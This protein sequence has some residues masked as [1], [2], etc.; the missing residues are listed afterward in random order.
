MASFQKVLVANRG[1]VASRVFRALHG[2][3]IRS[4]AVY[5]DVDRELP[6][7]AE[8]GQ[9]VHL[10][11]SAP[12]ESYLS[13]D[14]VLAAA[15]ECGADA[16]HPGYGFLAENAEFA[17]RVIDAGLR[18]IGPS[19]RWLHDMGHKTQARRLAQQWGLPTGAGT[20]VVD[21]ADPALPGRAAAI[22]YP[23]MVKPAAGG[24]G[25]GMMRVETPE[26]LADA[27]RSARSAAERGFGVGDVYLEKL[28]R[29]PRHVEIQL[30]GD[31]H[32]HVAH[33]FD[34]DC[35]VQRRNQKVIEEAPAPGIATQKRLEVLRRSAAA[36]AA[37]GYDNI[38]TLE[39][40]MSSTG[41][42]S[43][44]EMN[45]RL[46]VEHGVSEEVTGVDLVRG[47]IRSAAGDSLA[48]ILP[49]EIAVRGHAIEARVC[50]EDPM[51]FFPSVGKL[52]V[53]RPPR[54]AGVRVET[55]YGEGSTVTPFYDSLLAKV[56]VHGKDRDAAIAGLQ[57][58]LGAFE[59]RGVK[60]N[61]PA[62]QMVLASQEFRSGHVHTG[63]LQE[64]LDRA[65]AASKVSA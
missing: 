23:V 57:E 54:H 2:L 53:F 20:D 18:F 10:G 27:L 25:I 59:V 7:V 1:A 24:G 55:G 41:E 62:I 15:A 33:V 31:A 21:P 42:F 65:K 9:A 11:G 47:Q 43:F 56:I 40:L 49:G 37:A 38:G 48:S 50:A 13:I 32:G 36:L 60:T 6:Y 30:L 61:I 52:E 35:S 63:L 4:V 28:I 34:R 14:R 58:A 29:T 39:M 45:T 44:L 17:R 51:R 19:P 26:Q 8:A 64:L 5:S 22:G 3:D 46:Q 16:I 12:R